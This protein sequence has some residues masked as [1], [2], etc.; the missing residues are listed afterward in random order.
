VW[1]INVFFSLQQTLL[2]YCWFVLGDILTGALH[3]LYCKTLI[4][5]VP[6]NARIS[7]SWRLRET[8]GSRTCDYFSVRCY[9]SS[10]PLVQPVKTPKLRSPTVAPA[11]TTISII[12]SCNK[13][14][15][16]DI[17]VP[18]NPGPPGKW[19]LKQ[20]VKKHYRWWLTPLCTGLVW[21]TL[22]QTFAV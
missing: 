15:N 21:E 14:Q 1:Q 19:T 7:R 11:D 16:G 13:V 22:P 3:V 12:L 8:N 20:R 18:A 5:R 17:L 9:Y 6:F 4:V 10:S 2:A